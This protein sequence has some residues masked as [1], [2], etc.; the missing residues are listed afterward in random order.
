MN[1]VMRFTFREPV[2][3][4]AIEQD[5]DLA[6]LVAEFLYGKPRVRLEA[7]YDVNTSDSNLTLDLSGPAGETAAQI[8]TGLCAIRFGEEGYRV[9]RGQLAN[10]TSA[11]KE[12]RL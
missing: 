9:E 10:L 4:E 3:M 8:F 1:N 11:V 12:S 6:L 7:G 2:D 5:I